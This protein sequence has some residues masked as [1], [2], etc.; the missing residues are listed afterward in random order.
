MTN[1]QSFLH[2]ACQELGLTIN[3][4]FLLT[5]CDD[6]EINA[7][8]LLPQLGAPN[9][10]IIVNHYDELCGTVSKLQ[11]MGYSYSVLDDPSPTEK[12]D[13]ESYIEM[14]SDWGWG[15]VNERKPDWMN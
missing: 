1:L 11:S 7:Q 14:F 3:V 9:G 8:A 12:F 2:R 10:M 6:I 4:P 5:M 13:L 15:T